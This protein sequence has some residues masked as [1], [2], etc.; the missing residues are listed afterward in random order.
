VDIWALGVILY[1]LLV[2]RPP[3]EAKDQ[4]ETIHRIT[5]VFYQDPLFLSYAARELIQKVTYM[6]LYIHLCGQY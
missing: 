1:E 2:G 5:H 3:F 6:L 4:T